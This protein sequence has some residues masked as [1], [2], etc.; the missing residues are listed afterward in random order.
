MKA[1][2]TGGAGFI[3]SHLV[4]LLLARGH[5]VAV[6][7]NLTTGSRKNLRG[8]EG[9]PGWSFHPVDVTDI[10]AIRPL[11]ERADWVFHLAALADVVP[12][13]ERPLD[14][15]RVNV[16][17]TAAVVEA[18]RLAGV[19]RL[20][21]AA[22]SSCY[23]IPDEVPTPETA[24]IRPRYPYALTKYLGEQVVLHWGQ[25]YRLPVV[26]VP[27]RPA[28]PDRTFADT[29]RIR[30]RL[31]WRPEVSFEEGVRRMLARLEDWRDAPVWTPESI[32]RATRE[33][34]EFLAE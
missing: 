11:F 14:Y 25:V 20:V 19:K 7:D 16:D 33:W 31:G 34:F 30:E 28:E 23:G 32:S 5:E 2:V 8:V 12:S 15:F 1:I 21:Y 3:G 6:L 22:S 17:G 13:I 24:P 4:E 9:Q 29:T 10:Q 26:H 27:K 18:A